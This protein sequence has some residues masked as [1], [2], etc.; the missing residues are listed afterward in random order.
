MRQKKPSS[1]LELFQ[2]QLDQIL[3]HDNPLFKLAHQAL[4]DL[5]QRQAKAKQAQTQ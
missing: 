1:E 4:G 2:V 3:D 5:Y